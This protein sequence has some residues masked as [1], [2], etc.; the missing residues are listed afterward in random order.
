[1][2]E[3]IE[4]LTVNYN[5][6][7]LIDRLI[8]SV[9]DIEG[10]YFIRVIDGSDKEPFKTEIIE[11]CEKYNNVVLQQQGWNIHHG[12]GMDLGISTSKYEW[13]L[14]LDSDSYIIQPIIKKMYEATNNKKIVGS[15]I[16]TIYPGYANNSWIKYYHP[17]LLLINKE[18]YL[19]LKTI[20]IEF[21][22]HGAPAIAINKYLHDNK[23][24]DV[25]GVDFWKY[26][27][28]AES[29]IDKYYSRGGRGTV[30]R[31]GYNI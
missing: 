2:I 9:R 17:M 26:I 24:F 18:Y 12:R 28:V 10:D 30:D 3:N 11:V 20:G 7:D 25:V 29:D 5:T 23:I 8:K 14:L 15:C 6:S 31:F 19:S 1:M 27:G 16:L 22:H 21:I 4:I 13:C